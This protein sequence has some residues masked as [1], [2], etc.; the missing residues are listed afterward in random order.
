MKFSHGLSGKWSEPLTPYCD[1]LEILELPLEWS[2]VLPLPPL[3]QLPLRR[4]LQNRLPLH[5]PHQQSSPIRPLA[6]QNFIRYLII[7][8]IL[9][10]YLPKPALQ[11]AE[12][13]QST[14]VESL[15]DR[16]ILRKNPSS[17]SPATITSSLVHGLAFA[18]ITF[19]TLSL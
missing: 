19:L 14:K 4:S 10:V 11:T 12:L 7:L 1:P 15:Q 2:L 8:S 9:W 17:V 3:R 6:R 18:S 16:L 5:Q 13:N